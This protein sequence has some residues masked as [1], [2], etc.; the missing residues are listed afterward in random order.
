M[1]R[2]SCRDTSLVPWGIHTEQRRRVDTAGTGGTANPESYFPASAP[3]ST[4]PSAFQPAPPSSGEPGY[5]QPTTH[6]TPQAHPGNQPPQAL[7]QTPPQQYAVVV[8]NF[9]RTVYEYAEQQKGQPRRGVSTYEK[10]M[11]SEALLVMQYESRVY[12]LTCSPRRFYEDVIDRMEAAYIVLVERHKEFLTFLYQ[13]QQQQMRA[14]GQVMGLGMQQGMVSA[15]VVEGQLKAIEAVI[16]R[17]NAIYWESVNQQTAVAQNKFDAALRRGVADDGIIAALEQGTDLIESPSIYPG[18]QVAITGQHWARDKYKSALAEL[19]LRDPQ[20][21]REF[22]Q[23][24][25]QVLLEIPSDWQG[26]YDGETRPNGVIT[27]NPFISQQRMIG[28][29]VHNT[30]HSGDNKSRTRDESE[31]YAELRENKSWQRQG[32]PNMRVFA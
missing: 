20:E 12:Y 29:T 1:T 8:E 9:D 11:T 17:T 27:C 22:W 24:A 23:Q 10:D 30:A 25:T 6:P 15:H 13:S 31:A 21:Y 16:E 26:R 3:V 4:A 7:P 2:K 14:A 32:K 28:N 18:K 5:Y 19:A